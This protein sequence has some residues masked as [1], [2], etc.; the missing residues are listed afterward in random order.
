M[1]A[2]VAWVNPPGSKHGYPYICSEN[3]D[4]FS[5]SCLPSCCSPFLTLKN[6][7]Q[8]SGQCP[9]CQSCEH[10]DLCNKTVMFVPSWANEAAFWVVCAYE[11]FL[12][13]SRLK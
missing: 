13:P 4:I 3:H 2:T 10:V 8:L 12:H 1:G 9:L 5:L 7:K 6:N 11:S